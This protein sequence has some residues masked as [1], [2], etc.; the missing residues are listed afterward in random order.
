MSTPRSGRSMSL[1]LF[2][3]VF[4]DLLGFGL[5][6][7]ILPNYIRDL[8]GSEV[9]V[10]FAIALFSIMQFLS[11]PFL[12][13]LSDRIGRRPV[14]LM[15][16]V[17]NSLGY[18]LLGFSE[19]IVLLFI[20]RMISGM[21]SGNISVAQA[22][23]IDVTP[24]ERRSGALGLIGAAFGLGFIFG[25][26][27]GGLI[28]GYF[29]FAYVGWFAACLCLLNFLLAYFILKESIPQKTP[30]APLKLIPVSDYREAFKDRLV[31][32]I[33]L[34][35]FLYV[36]AFF[37]FQVCSTLFWEEHFGLNEQQRGYAFAFLGISTAVVQGLLIRRLSARFGD[38]RLL[39]AGNIGM[40]VILL[41]LG[42]VP[43]GLFLLLELPLIAL[44][45][46]VNGPVGPS[47]L[48][49]L[50]RETDPLKQGKIV[51]LY[52]SFG[53]LARVVGPIVGTSLYATH[54]LIPF[55]TA[56]VLLLL[57]ARWAFGLVRDI[58]AR[59][60]NVVGQPGGGT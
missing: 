21:A 57:N 27:A 59:H 13:G 15:T 14:L 54:Y 38:E 5:V 1:V 37:L 56:S 2:L 22:Y 19:G 49:L 46:I 31:L 42:L 4:I 6:I 60:A 41:G 47:S 9:W 34:I 51:G 8:M 23:L 20:A 30:D 43:P 40:A 32:R 28:M 52:Q 29:G 12:G 25:P 17:A 18:L 10:G 44:M 45:A 11:T 36:G 55:F 3:T 53:S 39:I 33:F 16:L 24:P 50:S 26:P 58:K 7:P 48:A 35:N